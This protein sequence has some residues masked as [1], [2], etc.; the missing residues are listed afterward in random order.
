MFFLAEF[1]LRHILKETDSKR[2]VDKLFLTV[3][4][5]ILLPFLGTSLGS[6]AVFL[7]KRNRKQAFT[8]CL[9]GFAGGVMLAASVWSLLLPAIEHSSHLEAFA[10]LPSAVGF[11]VG[12]AAM[13]MGE[14][15]VTGLSEIKEGEKN[16]LITALAVTV[17]NLPEGMAVGLVFAA[18]LSYPDELSASAA[19]SLSLGIA[20]QNIPEGAIVSLPLCSGTRGK[21]KAFLYGVLS[22]VVEPIGAVLTLLF[23]SF[24]TPLMPYFLSFAAG[25]MIFVVMNELSDE[26]QT[27]KGK[28]RGILFF[29]LGFV[30]MMS[31]DVALG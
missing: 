29:A 12:I 8:D 28:G 27:Q 15:V 17:H 6:S 22:G 7:M 31:L 16:S 2:K 24:F 23:A 21:P 13:L 18:L 30:I 10:F 26:M 5:G 20:I 11:F 3:V 25:T 1:I 14:R 4:T 9:C 19:L